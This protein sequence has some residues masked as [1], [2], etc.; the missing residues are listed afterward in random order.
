MTAVALLNR[1][2]VC[3]AVLDEIRDNDELAA[4]VAEYLI[5]QAAHGVDF[6]TAVASAL[7]WLRADTRAGPGHRHG[8]RRLSHPPPTEGAPT[9]M[10]T[11]TPAPPDTRTREQ[12]GNAIRDAAEHTDARNTMAIYAA[13]GA[14]VVSGASGESALRLVLRCLG[15]GLTGAEVL[16]VVAE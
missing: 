8:A 2:A 14:L 4:A 5:G 13:L 12:L 16:A 1:V 9:P 11:Q 6:P 7:E 15:D 10:T 3:D